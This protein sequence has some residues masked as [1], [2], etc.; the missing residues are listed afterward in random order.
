MLERIQ[1]ILVSAGRVEQQVRDE[2]R[3][4]RPAEPPAATDE[5]DQQREQEREQQA[6]RV[7]TVAQTLERVWA[8]AAGGHDVIEV[9]RGAAEEGKGA[10]EQT[11]VAAPHDWKHHEEADR[12]VNEE[13]PHG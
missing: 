1:P 7:G 5:I 8:E 12:A 13:G 9:D 3:E 4:N 10:E 2:D 6:V 11:F